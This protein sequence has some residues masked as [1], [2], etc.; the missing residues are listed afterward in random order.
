MPKIRHPCN[1][2]IVASVKLMGAV[3]DAR[4]SHPGALE[5]EPQRGSASVVPSNPNSRLGRQRSPIAQGRD[6]MDIIVVGIDVSKD[7]LDVACAAERRELCVSAATRAGHR[8]AGRAA[9]GGCLR[10]WSRWRRPAASRRWWRPAWARPACRSWWSIRRRCGP[11]PRR[12]GKRAKTDPIDAAVIAH[13][14]RG[15]E[16]AGA[17]AAGRRDTQMLA[18]LVARRRQII[19]MI[20]A[21]KQRETR[22]RHVG[23]QEEHR[24][25]AQG[26]AEG[27]HRPSTARS[28]MP[29]AARR[30]GARRRTCW[31]PFP[32]SAR[33]SPAR[34]S[35]NCPSSARSTAG[36]SRHS[37]ASPPSPASRASGAAGASSA[38]A[39]LPSAPRC[40]WARM[41]A[42]RHNPSS[43]DFHQRLVAAGKPKMVALI[44]V[45][46][47]LLTI[48]NAIIRDRR[49]WQNA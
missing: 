39:A 11:S 17:A 21:E 31:P 1:L 7:R 10:R 47:K 18:D 15:D 36:R 40:S 29:C 27:T 32:A 5:P 16:A 20:V 19:Q 49:P 4:P 48:L 2:E 45:A 26:A 8:C 13:F 41:V 35:P 23:S 6:K 9:C 30:H 43:H 46:R 42:A 25:A 12:S 44:A 28:T 34:C 38:A 22:A 33:S 24:A 3:A 37:P 14:A